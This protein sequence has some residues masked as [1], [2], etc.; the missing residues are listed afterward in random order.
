VQLCIVHQIRHSLN[1]VPYKDRRAVAADLKAIYTAPTL[2]DAET[3]LLQFAETWDVKYPM[4][5][6]SWQRNWDR[7]TPFLSYPAEIR[8]A[9]YTTNAIESLNRSLRKVIK[10]RGAFPTDDAAVKLLYLALHNAAKKWTLPIRN[11]K[12]ALN[13]FA[14]MFGDRVPR[15]GRQDAPDN[16]PAAAKKG[17]RA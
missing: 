4:I 13:R 12:A 2:E 6:Q 8:K 1:Y 7:L 15:P 5:S 11:W 9:I 16:A 3:Q 17:N 10:N 14:I